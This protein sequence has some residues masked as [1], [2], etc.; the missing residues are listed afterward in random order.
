M[1][2]NAILHNFK[3]ADSLQDLF[4]TTRAQ[5]MDRDSLP[6]TSKVNFADKG[7]NDSQIPAAAKWAMSIILLTLVVIISVAAFRGNK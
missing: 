2:V 7:K 4:A 5:L 3:S 1:I 6:G